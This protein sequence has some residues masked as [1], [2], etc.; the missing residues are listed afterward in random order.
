MWVAGEV[1]REALDRGFVERGD[2]KAWAAAIIGHE[3]PE[4]KIISRY[5]A[6]SELG[7]DGRSIITS[8]ARCGAQND[9]PQCCEIV[10]DRDGRLLRKK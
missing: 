2:A 7:H 8:D 3:H 9:V 6:R 5:S 4:G 10:L 1:E